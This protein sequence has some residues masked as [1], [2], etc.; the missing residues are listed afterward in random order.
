MD[1]GGDHD[2]KFMH[3]IVSIGG[4]TVGPI[5]RAVRLRARQLY[6]DLE[7]VGSYLV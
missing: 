4:I 3:W 5:G 2:S 6:H 7:V 1:A